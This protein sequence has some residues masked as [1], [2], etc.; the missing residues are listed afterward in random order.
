MLTGW[1]PAA[2]ARRAQALFQKGTG[3][4]V[5]EASWGWKLISATDGLVLAGLGR[6]AAVTALA[7]TGKLSAALTQLSWLPC[8][9]GV[10]GLANLAGERQDARQDAKLH[11]TIVVMVRVYLSLAAAAACVVVAVNPA[12]VSRWVGATM[13]AGGKANALLALI[14]IVMTFAHALSVVPSVLGQ[15]LQ[16]GSR[17][18]LFRRRACRSRRS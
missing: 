16:I 13:F 15:R 2:V 9:S 6:P 18:L 4:W 12:F 3:A 14:A 8:D 5:G 17:H 11:E 10:I 7:C 1:R